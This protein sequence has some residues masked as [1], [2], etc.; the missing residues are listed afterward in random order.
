M[1]NDFFSYGYGLIFAL[2]KLHRYKSGRI[3]F[4]GNRGPNYQESYYAMI[5]CISFGN[6]L[7]VRGFVDFTSIE[8]TPMYSHL[9]NNV[10]L[11]T[12]LI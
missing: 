7:S 6:K 9:V 2:V 3:P 8:L 11:S 10:K 12:T 1:L 5:K 4:H